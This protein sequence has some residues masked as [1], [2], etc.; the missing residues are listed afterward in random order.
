MHGKELKMLQVRRP[1]C[2]FQTKNFRDLK[3][4][5]LMAYFRNAFS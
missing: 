5:D 1:A 3:F 2:F 4:V